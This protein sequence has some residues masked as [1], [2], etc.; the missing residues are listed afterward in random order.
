MKEFAKAV[1]GISAVA[2]LGIQAVN[3]DVNGQVLQWCIIAITAMVLG[4]DA[5]TEWMEGRKNTA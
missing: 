3:H 1:V 5:V 2:I 4:A